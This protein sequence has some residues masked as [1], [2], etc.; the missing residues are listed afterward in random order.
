MPS[1]FDVL[2]SG[3][4]GGGVDAWDLDTGAHL[5]SHTNP[6]LCPTSTSTCHSHTSTGRHQLLLPD[7]AKAH[8]HTLGFSLSHTSSSSTSSSTSS[9]LPSQFS[10]LC[11][12]PSGLYL[13]A[14]SAASPTVFLFSQRTA[15][16]V[17]SCSTHYKGVRALLWTADERF[18]VSGGEDGCVNV[19]ALTDVLADEELQRPL[20]PF[21]PSS[22]LSSGAGGVGGEVKAHCSFTS[23]SL[24]VTALCVAPSSAHP[25]LLS[26]SLDH[27]V[28][29]HSLLSQETVQR[30]VFPCALTCLA[31]TSTLSS[32][33]AGGSDGLIYHQPLTHATAPPPSSPP[34]ATPTPMAGHAHPVTALSLSFDCSV[35]VSSSRDGTLRVWDVRTLQCIRV[36]RQVGRGSFDWCQVVRDVGEGRDWPTLRAGRRREEEA[37]VPLAGKSGL[38]VEEEEVGRDW[39][40]DWRV[41]MG[42]D[43]RSRL[44]REVGG[45]RAK[46]VK[47]EAEV[48][49]WTE[50]S[51][52]MYRICAQ[53]VLRGVQTAETSSARVEEKVGPETGDS[54]EVAEEQELTHEV[55]GG[56]EEADLVSAD[57]GMRDDEEK[58]DSGAEEV[59]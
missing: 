25:L 35:L 10:A 47:A 6:R 52:E 34:T 12:S 59:T 24:P 20:R 30:F 43:E 48:Q 32:L 29:V 27:T 14:A 33:F 17:G 56:N 50:L 28:Q 19:T 42:D 8:V 22:L 1:R 41:L 9:S 51:G 49:R 54:E 31:V 38:R 46:R 2:L 45:E 36:L 55:E 44:L 4:A 26:A 58:E 15:S 40:E 21:V 18:V 23:H 3:S 16:L 57:E 39:M 7:T 37:V 13:A 53:H 11:L 5:Y